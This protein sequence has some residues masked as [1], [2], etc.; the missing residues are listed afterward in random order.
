M[1]N[2]Q[3]PPEDYCKEARPAHCDVGLVE[4]SADFN[5]ALAKLQTKNNVMRLVGLLLTAMLCGYYRHKL[6]EAIH[7]QGSGVVPGCA[8]HCCPC[9]HSCAL[10]Q[11]AR[12]AKRYAAY[13]VGPPSRDSA[14]AMSPMRMDGRGAVGV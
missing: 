11:E 9:T 10:C 8:L 6:H 12:A 5:A 7:G 3:A 4:A 1:A 2:A 14:H 13:S